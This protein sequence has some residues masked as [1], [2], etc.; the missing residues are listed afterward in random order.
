MKNHYVQRSFI[1]NTQK[2]REKAVQL[3]LS[4]IK[5]EIQGK[6]ILLVDDSIV[7]GTTSKSIV[8]TLLEYGAKNVNLAITCP[9][10]RHG[11]FYGM[12]FPDERELIASHKTISE[13]ADWIGVKHL[14]I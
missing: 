12:D 8:R 1:L 2:A 6:D 5:S 10:I 9:A 14:F 11:C 7:R 3:K 13:I 4:P